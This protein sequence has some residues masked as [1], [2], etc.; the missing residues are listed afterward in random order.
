[1]NWWDSPVPGVLHQPMLQGAF[2]FLQLLTPYSSFSL[3]SSFSFS[4]LL[5]FLLPLSFPFLFSLFFLLFHTP[6]LSF[7]P[8]CSR[9]KLGSRVGSDC[10]MISWIQLPLGDLLTVVREP[11]LSRQQGL[12]EARDSFPAGT[13]TASHPSSSIAH[14]ANGTEVKWGVESTPDLLT[15]PVTSHCPDS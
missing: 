13:W 8:C 2:L 5:S 4:C 1:M 3:S 14:C 10:L 11:F 15:G 6:L 9:K 12:A 7:N